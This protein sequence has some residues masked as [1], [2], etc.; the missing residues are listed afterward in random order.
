M[1]SVT[2]Q[3][4]TKMAAALIVALAEGGAPASSVWLAFEGNPMKP[5]AFEVLDFMELVGRLTQRGVVTNRGYFLALT[6]M[7]QELAK[8]IEGAMDKAQAQLEGRN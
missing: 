7:G 5:K 2:Q 4:M 1:S 6:P 8:K 3:D